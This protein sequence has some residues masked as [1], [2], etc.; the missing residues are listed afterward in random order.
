MAGVDIPNSATATWQGVLAFGIL[1]GGTTLASDW[2]GQL[3]QELSYDGL[4]IGNYDVGSV[5]F[6]IDGNMPVTLQI[7]NQS[8]QDLDETDLDSQLSDAVSTI[9]GKLV[10]GGVTQ[11]TGGDSGVNSGSGT[12]GNTTSFGTVQAAAAA[13]KS[14]THACGDPSWGFFDDPIQ[15]LTCL[16]SKGLTTIGLLAIG[17]IVGIILI[18]GLERRPTV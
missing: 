5:N 11:V 1:A 15:W 16:T 2:I 9:G 12:A 4:T 3:R 8:G 13:A 7:I 6:F 10:S 14:T 18:V 17:L